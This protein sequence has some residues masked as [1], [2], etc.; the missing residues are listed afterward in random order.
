MACNGTRIYTI[1][2]AGSDGVISSGAF[3]NDGNIDLSLTVGGPVQ[4]PADGFYQ[5][6]FL[7]ADWVVG[8]TDSTISIP[9]ATHL[10]GAAPVV[11]IKEA[12]E[13]VGVDAL[14]ITA[15]GDV[16]LSVPNGLPFDGTVLIRR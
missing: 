6:D 5:L 1:S 11:T 4:V 15:T 16:T 3:D 2:G 14:T 12:D 7:I 13:V 9:V 8:G 10:K